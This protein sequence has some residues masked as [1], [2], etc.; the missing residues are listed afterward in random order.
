MSARGGRGSRRGRGRGTGGN[1]QPPP[2]DFSED[3]SNV[4]VHDP[5]MY[6]RY[7]PLNPELLSMICA[8]NQQ[9]LPTPP[10]PPQNVDIENAR[11]KHTNVD[12]GGGS[13]NR[14][15]K[16]CIEPDGDSYATL[17]K[18]WETP[19]FQKLSE[20]NRKNRS[21]NLDG[22]GPSK[23]SC[24]ARPMSA[25]RRRL[26]AR[27][28]SEEPTDIALFSDTHQIRDPK[29]KGKWVDGKSQRKVRHASGPSNEPPPNILSSD[30]EDG[31]DGAPPDGG[32]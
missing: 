24:G 15:I 9:L 25:W 2:Q 27:N 26:T 5:R 18:Y 22:D 30:D 32:D 16:R 31:R 7:L 13:N 11:E 6:G 29:T 23:H 4:P 8:G 17:Q 21:S 20:Q 3:Q 12:E 28:K 1:G 10:P 14:N 19:E